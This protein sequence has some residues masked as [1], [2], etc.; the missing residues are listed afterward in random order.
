MVF[1]GQLQ[2]VK[3]EEQIIDTTPITVPLCRCGQNEVETMDK[4]GENVCAD[5]AYDES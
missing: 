2:G 5:C 1:F 4:D 3:V